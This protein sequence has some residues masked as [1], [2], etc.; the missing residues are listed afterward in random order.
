MSFASVFCYVG[1]IE[2][3]VTIRS[4]FH[5]GRRLAS[6]GREPDP[7]GW[8]YITTWEE[9]MRCGYT[10]FVSIKECWEEDYLYSAGRR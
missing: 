4:Q 5:Q 7:P 6:V 10:K 8:G 3:K 2:H 9:C 1:F